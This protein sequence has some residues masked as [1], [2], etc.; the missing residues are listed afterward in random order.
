MGNTHSYQHGVAAV[1]R[2]G[3]YLYLVVAFGQNIMPQHIMYN[4]W[5]QDILVTI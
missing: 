4:I 3:G 1:R 2:M 5:S